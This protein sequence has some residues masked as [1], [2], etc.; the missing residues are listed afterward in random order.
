VR[1]GIWL[2][3]DWWWWC[4]GVVRRASFLGV[5]QPRFQKG[6]QTRACHPIEIPQAAQRIT[7]GSPHL[8]QAAYERHRP[9]LH[10]LGHVLA[11]LVAA[12][13]LDLRWRLRCARLVGL[14][15]L[16]EGLVVRFGRWSQAA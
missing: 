9:L 1:L 15:A 11:G 4:G 10:L 16:G 5:R 6:E 7:A 8:Q 2:G 14:R 3:S 12:G 13:A